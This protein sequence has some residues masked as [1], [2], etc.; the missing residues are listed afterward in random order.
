MLYTLWRGRKT[1]P[2]I[3][4]FALSLAIFSAFA[5]IIEVLEK[6]LTPFALESASLFVKVKRINGRQ[7]I[8]KIVSDAYIYFFLIKRKVLLRF[9]VGNKRRIMQ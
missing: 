3:S 5:P 8:A 9:V 4:F 2:K 7:T 1:N 6:M